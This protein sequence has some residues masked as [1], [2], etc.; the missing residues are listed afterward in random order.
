MNEI[1]TVEKEILVAASIDRV[2]R[3]LTDH[4]EF[5]RW[6]RVRLDQPFEV[7]GESTGHMTIPG[8]EHVLWEA[9]ILEMKQHRLFALSGPPFVENTDVD[10]SKEP[11]LTTTFTLTETEQDTLVNVVES[12]F[13]KLSPFIRVEARTG[14]TEGWDFQMAN[15][16]SYLS[17]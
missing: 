11:W 10:L 16:R 6:F 14:N 3:A 12:G 9:Q 17:Q 5:G 15:L 2:W 7:G 13:S 1:D 4:L 8:Y